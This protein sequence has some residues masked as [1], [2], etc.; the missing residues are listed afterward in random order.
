VHAYFGALLSESLVNP[1]RVSDNA[2]E[3]PELG[4][5]EKQE[6]MGACVERHTKYGEP[7]D[8][9]AR[10]YQMLRDGCTAAPYGYGDK[11]SS[12]VEALW[13]CYQRMLSEGWVRS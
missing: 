1:Y 3:L 5:E 8:W 12:A 4:W 11:P 10:L 9:Q 7:D 2:H 6:Q 13:T